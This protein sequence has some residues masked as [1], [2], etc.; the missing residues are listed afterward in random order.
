[1]LSCSLE[2]NKVRDR[3]CRK[4]CKQCKSFEAINDTL[5]SCCNGRECNEGFVLNDCECQELCPGPACLTPSMSATNIMGKSS[6]TTLNDADDTEKRTEHVTKSEA[7]NTEEYANVKTTISST[8]SSSRN[9]EMTTT[10]QT[11]KFKIMKLSPKNCAIHFKC[12][13]LFHSIYRYLIIFVLFFHY[14][15]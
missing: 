3:Y 10:R 7:I 12:L 4:M 6:V 8:T 14:V 2:D 9:M 15:Y 11:K 5:G 1:M 13:K